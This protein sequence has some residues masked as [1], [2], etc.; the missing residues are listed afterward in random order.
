MFLIYRLKQTLQTLSALTKHTTAWIQAAIFRVPTLGGVLHATAESNGV[1]LNNPG[2][3]YSKKAINTKPTCSCKTVA[4]KYA[5]Q[6]VH[7]IK[8]DPLF[9]PPIYNISKA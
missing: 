1:T 3:L 4:L 7:A 2:T 5:Q 9:H 6:T 8:H